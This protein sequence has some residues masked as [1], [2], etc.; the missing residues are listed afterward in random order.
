M[1]IFIFQFPYIINLN[2]GGR[3]FTTHY[4]TLTKYPNNKLTAMFTGHLPVLEDEEG[5]Y[6]IDM[7]PKV[8]SHILDFLRFGELP[9]PEEASKVYRAAD[10]LSIKELTDKLRWCSALVKE[11][12][13][14]SM[15]H[16]EIYSNKLAAMTSI[17]ARSGYCNL[18]VQ[19]MDQR[20]HPITSDRNNFT[21][22]C[23]KDLLKL[24][25]LKAETINY[26]ELA[27]FLTTG[28]EQKGYKTSTKE[29]ICKH[30]GLYGMD[31]VRISLQWH[32]LCCTESE[33]GKKSTAIIFIKFAVLNIRWIDTLSGAVTLSKLLSPSEKGHTLKEK[34]LLPLGEFSPF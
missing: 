6:I 26:P 17:I 16:K 1:K 3:H 4:S 21:C 15:A 28:L 13:F 29:I 19:Y 22:K 14:D 31:L 18:I 24:S 7:D 33:W 8:F 5:R 10:H 9:P 12:F 2:V 23:G 20:P 34:N 25:T 30:C 27:I 32:L 11:R